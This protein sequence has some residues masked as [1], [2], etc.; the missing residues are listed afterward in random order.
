LLEPELPKLLEPLETP[1]K[2]DEN[3]PDEPPEEY[4]PD[5]CPPD[6]CPP[7]EPPDGRLYEYPLGGSGRPAANAKQ[8]EINTKALIIEKIKFASPKLYPLKEQM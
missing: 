5:E 4:P 8:H 6:E 7:D 1:E 3:P 2:P